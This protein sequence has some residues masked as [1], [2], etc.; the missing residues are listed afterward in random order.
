M[1]VT[2]EKQEYMLNKGDMIMVKPNLVHGLTTETESKHILCIFSPELIS[3]IS[4]ELVRYVL[5][6]PVIHCS[7]AIYTE[8]FENIHEKMNIGKVKGFLYL[9]SDLFYEK[10]DFS[11]TD[12][13][14]RGSHLLQS[15]LIYV[16][17]NMSKACTIQEI[18]A[19]LDYSPSYLSRFFY[20]NMGMAYSD[21][22]RNI[23]ISHACNL[24]KN[25]DTSVI[26]ISNNC[27]YSSNGSFNRNFKQMTDLCPTA[28]RK[29]A[30]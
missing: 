15:I 14:V 17:E 20:A 1:K 6:T 28:Y 13:E 16:E 26:E 3:V 24:L 19:H 7:P 30:K 12:R 21:Y 27:G 22:V 4:N 10:L 8:L 23:K 18:S 29:N 11:R 5:K 2:I 9:I 25:T